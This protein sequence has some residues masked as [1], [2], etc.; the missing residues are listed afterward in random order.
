MKL[1]LNPNELDFVD[2]LNYDK[3]H[4]FTQFFI[5]G[6]NHRYKEIKHCLQKNVENTN[7]DYIHLLNEK[8]YSKKELGIESNK[9]IQS[10]IDKR[11]T[12]ENVFSYIRHKNLTGYFILI[13]SDI[14][15][16]KHSITRLKQSSFHLSKQM[17]ALLRYECNYNNLTKSHIFGPRPDS[18]DAWI[19]HS[20][21]PISQKEEKV[22]SFEFGKPGCDNKVIYLVSILG[23]KVINDPENF[24]IIHVH[25]SKKRSYTRNDAIHLPVGVAMPYGFNYSQLKTQLGIDLN[26]F[27][28]WSNNFTSLMFNDNTLLFN[29]ISSKINQNKN[30]IIP[31]ISGIENN[32]AVFARCVHQ[33][34]HNDIQPLVSYIKK[35]IP[36]MKNNAGIKLSQEDSVIYYSNLYLSAFDNCDFLGAWEPQG[37]Y[38]GHIA[39]SH[40]FMQNY[41]RTR[42]FIW[43]YTFDIFHYIYNQ[44]WTQALQKKRILLISPFQETLQEQIPIRRFIYD[45]VDLF[46]N[47]EFITLKP[48]Q[49]Q[50]DQPSSEFAVE[51]DK[52]K[53]NV[54]ELLDDFDVAL[55][56][57]GGYA[58]PICSH[59]Y[60]KGKSAIYVGGVLQMYFGILGNRWLKER[61][62]IVKL[63]Y[64][65]YWKR[66]KVSER[67]MNY[68]KVENGCYW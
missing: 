55:V 3:V 58:N 44:P 16:L 7:I 37:D 61:P 65:S 17:C 20:N 35:I 24:Q 63:F 25:S 47:C 43:A 26:K 57:C 19:F 54:N 41:Y 22:F 21:F 56:S 40:A 29:Y 9:I 42:T 1:I 6:N 67:P 28:I 50:A 27:S 51:F 48:P 39:Q 14:C 45:N 60:S 62:D 36:A 11:L 53:T 12:F 59:I 5:P 34:L 68:N 10:N 33:K 32:V 64:N 8:I 30:F 18:Q 49:T 52:F 46:P 2:E 15:I 23:Y 66:P 31:R 38:I 4:V 13:N